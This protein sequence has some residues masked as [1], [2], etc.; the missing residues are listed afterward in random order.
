SIHHY[1]LSSGRRHQVSLIASGGIRLASDS[2]KTI[3]RGAEA[4]LL[5]V[6]ALLAL[7][8]YAY[9]ATQ[10]DKTTTEKLVNLDIPW[11][12]KRL[13]NQMESRKIQIL[14][15]LGASGFKDIKK[16]VGEEGRLID[17]YELEERLQKEVLEDEDKPARHEQLN[18]ELKA[19]E[20]LP[21]GASPTYSELKKRVQ[22]L[23]SPHNFYELGDI[24]QTV[25]H[26][27]HVWPGMLIRTLGRMAAGEEE[28]FL[29]KNVKGTGLLGDGFDVMRILY[30][31]D[32]DVI[33]DAE[34]DD[35]STAL[36]LDK[37]LILQAPWMFG[38]KSVGSIGLDTWRAHVIA[39]R[40]LGV[41]YDTGEGGYPTCFF[42]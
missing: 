29:L 21:A 27:D 20:P 35:V 30:Q 25:Y 2:Q 22:R 18:N 38:G 17:F 3:Q 40:E 15:V 23:K 19:A 39:A 42:L 24:N 31:R 8:P 9:K 5:D 36:P 13:N 16:T 12:I 41:Q 6:A 33:P 7:D 26:R 37:D 4:T 14:E 11:A 32:P 28:M 34:L 10:E 1:L